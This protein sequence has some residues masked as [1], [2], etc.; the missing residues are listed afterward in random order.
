MIV[1]V[2]ACWNSNFD[3]HSHQLLSSSLTTISPLETLTRSPWPNK[4]CE[5]QIV[6]VSATLNFIGHSLLTMR[7]SRGCI[8]LNEYERMDGLIYTLIYPQKPMVKSRTLDLVNF[9]KV[10]GGQNACIAVMSYSGYDSE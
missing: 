9:D 4:L 5:C 7:A 6:S 2:I 1:I 3:V 10:P 8:G